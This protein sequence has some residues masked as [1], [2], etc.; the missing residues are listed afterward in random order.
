M[1]ASLF[2]IETLLAPLDGADGAGTDLR[3][4]YSPTSPY[5]KLRDARAEARAEERALETSEEAEP[6]VPQS[7]REVKRLG[8]DCIGSRSKDFEVAAWLLESLV[9]LDGLPGLIAG[10]ELLGGLLDRYWEPGFPQPDEDGM[11]VRAAPL[12][13]LSGEGADGTLMQPLRRLPL[14]RR[15]RVFSLY[16]WKIAEDTAAI[17]DEGENRRRR[18]A[19]YEAGVPE[20]KALET[21]A[22]IDAA[23]LRRTAQQAVAAQRAWA[24]LG[25]Q[26]DARFGDIAPNTRRVSDAL[27]QILAMATRLVG[28]VAEERPADTGAVA[29]AA[30]MAAVA[31]EGPA[32]GGAMAAAPRAL[33]TREDAIRQLED[34]AEFFRKTE[35]HSPLAYTLSDAVRRARL[36]L[37]ELLAEVLPD[38]GARQAM[39]TMLGIRTAMGENE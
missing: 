9:R 34:L 27:E 2:D 19:R 8:L 7:W 21:E 35:P 25:A 26:M 16:L 12:S 33:R 30:E 10:S 20:L 18:Q 36:P 3:S 28:P 5:Q 38:S 17:P 14:F 11:D 13:G 39:L 4:D 31:E 6:A 24:A 29:E 22:R 23:T 32:M 37:P 15:P 1:S